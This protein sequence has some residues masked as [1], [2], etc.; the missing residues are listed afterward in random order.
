[1]PL[2]KLEIMKQK[3]L[4]DLLVRLVENSPGIT[5]QKLFDKGKE[6]AGSAHLSAHEFDRAMVKLRNNG[7]RVTNKQWYPANHVAPPKVSNPKEP[8]PRQT[9]WAF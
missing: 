8:D 3:S 7:Y 5:T 2:S 6:W 9:R 1:M 4:D